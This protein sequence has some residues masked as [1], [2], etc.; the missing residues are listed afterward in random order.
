MVVSLFMG[1]IALIGLSFDGGTSIATYM[2]IS[3]VAQNAARLGAQQVVG[4]R[5]GNP[6]IDNQSAAD[7]IEQFTSS[8]KIR[9]TTEFHGTAVTV[10]VETKQQMKILG[11][12]GVGPRTIRAIRT[13]DLVSG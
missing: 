6:R 4:I 2:R 9:S 8:F 1:G 12:F 5:D 10:H 11:M 13:A 3:D 7:L